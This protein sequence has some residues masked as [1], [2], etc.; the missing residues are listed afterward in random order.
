V[1]GV[2]DL[3]SGCVVY[4]SRCCSRRPSPSGCSVHS[5][6]SGK[7]SRLGMAELDRMK[8]AAC[9]AYASSPATVFFFA[10]KREFQLTLN[11]QTHEG[12]TT[13]LRRSAEPCTSQAPMRDLPAAA[14]TTLAHH[15]VWTVQRFEALRVKPWSLNSKP[16][17]LNP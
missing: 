8:R 14:L 2:W 15:V 11:I 4:S 6:A 3:G 16:Y 7:R 13:H 5:H 12:V 17:T 10:Q 9:S 1:L